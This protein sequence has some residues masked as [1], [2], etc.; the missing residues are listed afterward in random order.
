MELIL[1]HIYQDNLKAGT[2][3]SSRKS[4]CAG[5]RGTV[6]TNPGEVLWSATHQAEMVFRRWSQ[7][8]ATLS[9]WPWNRA[10]HLTVRGPLLSICAFAQLATPPP[11]PRRTSSP[12]FT[13]SPISLSLDGKIPFWSKITLSDHLSSPCH[14]MKSRMAANASSGPEQ[15]PSCHPLGS[16]AT[17]TY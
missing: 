7:T 4:S 3:P 11:R 15:K 16:W 6:S 5:A 8:T 2:C 10:K 12:D 9:I 1:K 17:F 14:W 13:S